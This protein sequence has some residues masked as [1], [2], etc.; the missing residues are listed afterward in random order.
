MVPR[1]TAG[2]GVRRQPEGPR[3]P[4]ELRWVSLDPTRDRIPQ[5]RSTRQALREPNREAATA[6]SSN[7]LSIERLSRSLGRAF[8]TTPPTESVDARIGQPL[9]CNTARRPRRRRGEARLQ[10]GSFDLTVLADSDRVVSVRTNT[11][12]HLPRGMFVRC[13]LRRVPLA[14]DA[15]VGAPRPLISPAGPRVQRI[16]SRPRSE[17]RGSVG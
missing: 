16:P 9:L 12:R 1:L 10:R 13:R 14:L 5:S 3:V 6:G 4:R 2:L 8:G 11:P 17:E 15:L 7:L